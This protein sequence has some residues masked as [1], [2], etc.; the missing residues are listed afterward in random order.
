MLAQ[1]FA[2]PMAITLT[3]PI[4]SEA[5]TRMHNNRISSFCV[6]IASI[7]WLGTASAQAPGAV[8]PPP[9][10]EA[11]A[12]KAVCK[13]AVVSPVSGFAECVDPRGAPV[14]PAPKRPDAPEDT[15]DR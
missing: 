1:W 3:V 13:E 8:T 10:P 6:A 2:K 15:P 7:G 4:D 11:A 9:A 5:R 12:E 14:A